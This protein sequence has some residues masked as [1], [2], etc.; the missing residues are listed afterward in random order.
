MGLKEG[1][2]P[3]VRGAGSAPRPLS[4]ACRGHPRGCGE[5]NA[6]KLR[7]DLAPGSSPRVRGAGHLPSDGLQLG[8]VIPAGAGSSAG[9]IRP[10]DRHGVI[11]AG[12]GSSTPHATRWARWRGHPRGCGEQ[13]EQL[14]PAASPQGS[15]PRVRGAGAAPQPETEGSGVIPA[16]AGSRPSRRRPRRSRRGHP[17]GCGEQA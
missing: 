1:S 17:R 7:G 8:G 3:R 13:I 16:G 14:Q 12:A 9:V 6:E 5:P 2:S 15:S 4:G 10:A 11:P